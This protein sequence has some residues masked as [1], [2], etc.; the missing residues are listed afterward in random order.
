[1][2]FVPGSDGRNENAP[3]LPRLNDNGVQAKIITSL[4]IHAKMAL[5]DYNTTGQVVY[6][7]SENFS[8]V[9]LDQ[10]RELGILITEKPIIDWLESV[11]SQDWQVPAMKEP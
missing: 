8:N 2:P 7:G 9:S 11:F 6:L 10:N 5:A 1:V 4:Y 3:A